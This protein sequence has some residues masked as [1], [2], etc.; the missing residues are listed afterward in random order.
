M[1]KAADPRRAAKPVAQVT[2]S[3]MSHPASVKKAVYRV[4]IYCDIG[5]G[6]RRTKTDDSPPVDYTTAKSH[7]CQSLRTLVGSIV[8]PIQESVLELQDRQVLGT[9]LLFSLLS[10]SKSLVKDNNL[11]RM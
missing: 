2:G 5:R 8:N 11:L 4:R 3:I 10:V 6:D 9:H 7:D 1:R